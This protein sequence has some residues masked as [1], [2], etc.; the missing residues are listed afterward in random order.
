[1]RIQ[2]LILWFKGFKKVA[3]RV[4]VKKKVGLARR[5]TRQAAGSPF[6]EGIGS[7]S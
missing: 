4:N 7:P 2:I 3:N 6:C 5:V 1:M